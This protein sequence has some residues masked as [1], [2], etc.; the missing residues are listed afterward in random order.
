MNPYLKSSFP[1][2]TVLGI[3][4]LFLL[5]VSPVARAGNV[6][7]GDDFQN[8]DL[9][10]WHQS[11]QGVEESFWPIVADPDLSDDRHK[12]LSTPAMGTQNYYWHI[13][14]QVAAGSTLSLSL[15]FNVDQAN[16]EWNM[17]WSLLDDVVL[18]GGSIVGGYSVRVGGAG[19]PN[20]RKTVVVI[21]R[22][23]PKKKNSDKGSEAIL[24]SQ[25][26]PREKILPGWNTL[27]FRWGLDGALKV[28]LNGSEILS[29]KD[30]THKPAFRTLRIATYLSN[31]L[32]PPQSLP[33]GRKLFFGDVK[34]EQ[35]DQ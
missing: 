31:N 14:P 20:D 28:F 3:A 10:N 19:T 9:G 26:L 23:D 12:V 29:A 17:T 2:S 21:S 5:S 24:A 15:R 16:D 6:L 22:C 4:V 8:S 32:P 27:Q 30:T 11:P 13:E 35:I 25:E 1:Q 34:V 18:N 7:F 33:D